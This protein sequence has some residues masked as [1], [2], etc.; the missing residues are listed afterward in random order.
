[1]KLEKMLKNQ[2]GGVIKSVLYTGLGLAMGLLLYTGYY[3]HKED[4]VVKFAA[5]KTVE[6]LDYARE[7]WVEPTIDYVKKEYDDVKKDGK[8]DDQSND[9]SNVSKK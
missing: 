7:N 9:Q 4:N 2:K 6:G 1:M 8:K 5:K 3:Y